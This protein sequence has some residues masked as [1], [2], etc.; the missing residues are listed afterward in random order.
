MSL[1]PLSVIDD[2][3]GMGGGVG[4]WLLSLYEGERTFLPGGAGRFCLKVTASSYISSRGFGFVL[5]TT[6]YTLSG[7]FCLKVTASSYISS[8]IVCFDVTAGKLLLKVIASS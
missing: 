2:L 5:A 8:G 3:E 4:P 1:L 6:S 7:G